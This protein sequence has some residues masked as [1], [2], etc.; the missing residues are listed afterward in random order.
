MNRTLNGLILETL[1]SF[2]PEWE[3][4]FLYIL[5]RRILQKWLNEWVEGN[6]HALLTKLNCIL[7]NFHVWSNSVCPLKCVLQPIFLQNG[8]I[9]C[10]FICILHDV[11]L[12]YSSILLSLYSR[13]HA[14]CLV[15]IQGVP[16]KMEISKGYFLNIN[17]HCY[18]YT[19]WF[20]LN[21]E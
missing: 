18:Y 10:I 19:R 5:K 8:T 20:Y 13:F 9:L 14:A 21:E 7:L 4:C 12:V 1:L 3:H 11:R 6:Q 16:I 15:F 2:G 17:S